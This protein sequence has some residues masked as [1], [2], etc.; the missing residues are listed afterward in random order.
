MSLVETVRA[1]V[2]LLLVLYVHKRLQFITHRS[3]VSFLP[4]IIIVSPGS[5]IFGPEHR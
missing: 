2:T 5:M 3:S 1:Q 4:Y